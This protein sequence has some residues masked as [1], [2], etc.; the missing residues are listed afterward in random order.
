MLP[1]FS[2]AQP[3]TPFQAR[4][5]QEGFTNW[6]TFD[7]GRDNLALWKALAFGLIQHS[8]VRYPEVHRFLELKWR[9]KIREIIQIDAQFGPEKIE[10]PEYWEQIGGKFREMV[11][12][13]FREINKTVH[14]EEIHQHS[15]LN[16]ANKVAYDLLSSHFNMCICWYE[17]N[18]S[19]TILSHIFHSQAKGDVS[20]FI[21]IAIQGNRLYYLYHQSVESE[22][23]MD[24]PFAMKVREKGS[25][26]VI[27]SV[28]S[29]GT[30]DTQEEDR[31]TLVRKLVEV[32][33]AQTQ[34]L[35]SICDTVRP[36]VMGKYMEMVGKIR[37]VRSF[38]EYKGLETRLDTPA[39]NHLL[40]LTEPRPV[41]IES[42]PPHGIT[43]C[44]WYREEDRD[45]VSY[46]E[47]SFHRKCLSDYLL[48]IELVYPNM[49]KCPVEECQVLLPD[50]VLDLNRGIRE[51][52]ERSHLF[53]RTE[54]MALQHRLSASMPVYTS[55]R[56]CI[57]C[58]R[59][60]P[61][62]YLVKHGCSVCVYCAYQNGSELCPGCSGLFTSQEKEEIMQCSQ[63]SWYQ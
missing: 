54:M 59:T 56:T 49:P 60:I 11:L 13:F 33:E 19:E 36:E 47:H 43:T 8:Q 5:L 4:L 28:R 39:I 41:E 51:S 23:K 17:S 3:T 31:H 42:K 6:F 61:L 30:G 32:V 55:S 52:Y 10:L 24:F 58:H 53:R 29:E 20:L 27:N 25:P 45:F 40:T 18:A 37:S 14:I 48:E 2:P 38:S 16:P 1:V 15:Y 7:L 57:I 21:C 50:T 34:F 9:P 44:E 26:L 12:N 62:N 35:V 63:R 22:V 46:H